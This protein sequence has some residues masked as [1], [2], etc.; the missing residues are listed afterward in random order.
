MSQVE[1]HTSF[2]TMKAN[3]PLKLI[4]SP[5]VNKGVAKENGN[6][7]RRGIIIAWLLNV[8]LCLTLRVWT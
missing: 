8:Y 6:F 4:N 1:Q 3:D 7:F 5:I 2:G